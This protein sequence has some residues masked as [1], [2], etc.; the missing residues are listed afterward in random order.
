MNNTQNLRR[1]NIR[2]QRSLLS[3]FSKFQYNGCIQRASSPKK[4]LLHSKHSRW[5]AVFLRS[6]LWTVKYVKP[7]DKNIGHQRFLPLSLPGN[8]A[9]DISLKNVLE[10][11]AH[12]RIYT[13]SIKSAKVFSPLL[14]H[15]RA[16]PTELMCMKYTHTSSMK[17]VNALFVAAIKLF[18]REDRQA[19]GARGYFIT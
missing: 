17:T 3:L 4:Y 10:S 15:F 1:Q 2:R 14:F 5:V 7:L 6:L 18:P 16:S 13:S 8:R 9:L 11:I 12:V 19:S